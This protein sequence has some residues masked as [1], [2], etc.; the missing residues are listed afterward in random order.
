MNSLIVTLVFVLT[1]SAAFAADVDLVKGHLLHMAL[2]QSRF[3][4]QR[5]TG[6]NFEVG[7]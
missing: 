6:A 4:L 3:W 7:T 1:G 5:I 2:P